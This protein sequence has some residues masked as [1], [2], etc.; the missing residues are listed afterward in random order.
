MN[1]LKQTEV[2]CIVEKV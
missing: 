2:L 1:C